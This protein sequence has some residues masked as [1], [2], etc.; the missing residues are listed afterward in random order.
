MPSDK[1][2][3]FAMLSIVAITSFTFGL[4][5]GAKILHMERNDQWIQQAEKDCY[6]FALAYASARDFN[7]VCAGP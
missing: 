4:A 1:T 2:E 6:P 7:R 5:C 3:F